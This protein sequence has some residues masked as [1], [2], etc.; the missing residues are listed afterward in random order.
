MTSYE[1][2]VFGL[3]TVGLGLFAWAF[4]NAHKRVGFGPI[5]AT[6]LLA[7]VALG[8]VSG[9]LWAGT[10]TDCGFCDTLSELAAISLLL[11]ASGLSII[12]VWNLRKIN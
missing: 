9:W 8:F 2:I 6:V 1:T 4:P 5:V 10:E 11:T 7:C 3:P 12:T